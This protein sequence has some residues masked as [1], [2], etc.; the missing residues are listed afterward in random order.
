[1]NSSSY[2]VRLRFF[3]RAKFKV[4]QAAIDT[5]IDGVS[6]KF[7]ALHSEKLSD[8]GWLGIIAEGFPTSRI[9]LE[10]GRRLKTALLLSAIDQSIPVSV[11]E[12]AATARWSEHIKDSI[13]QQTG[14][15]IRENV[16]GL[17]VYEDDGSVI[18][19]SFSGEV[20]VANSPDA[21]LQR[22]DYYMQLE[23]LTSVE[24]QTALLMLSDAFNASEP[25][26]K[27]SLAISS[28][29]MLA[30]ESGWSKEQKLL[31]KIAQQAVGND[32]S[33]SL[34]DEDRRAVTDAID[35][36]Y[37]I[38]VNEGI[39]KLLRH[40]NL[41]ELQ[42]EWKAVYSERS[43]IFHGLA[44]TKRSNDATFAENAFR[45]S[46]TIVLTAVNQSRR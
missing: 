3:S 20:S 38:G 17:D 6:S 40:L 26:A 37:R 32:R 22:L 5:S 33:I 25:L 11:G 10:F 4:D 7:I 15:T 30:Q 21:F 44:A 8:G 18:F 41:D 46:K 31:L 35:R 43:K 39:R 12:D 19:P 13:K 1:M 28:V 29:E 34:E 24:C 42:S 14:A 36:A 16:H 2:T 27:A 23:P 9:G 45:L